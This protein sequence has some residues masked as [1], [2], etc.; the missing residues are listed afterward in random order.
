MN[1]GYMVRCLAVMATTAV[2]SCAAPVAAGEAAM[3]QR[4]ENHDPLITPNPHGKLRTWVPG[5]EIDTSNAF[6]QILGTNGRSCNTCHQLVAAWGT[7]VA[8]IGQRFEATYGTDP[9]FR[10]VDGANS[11]LMDVS[12]L[13]ARREAYSML[14]TYG[15][16]RIHMPMP[17][18]AEF[19][20][21]DVDDPWGYASAQELSL[22]RRPLPATNLRFLTSVMWDG[23]E[24][25]APF[26]PPMDPGEAHA[27]LVDSLTQQALNATLGHAQAM[28]PPTP[29]QLAAIVAFELSLT[30]AQFRDRRAGRLDDADALGGPRALAIQRFYVGIN[31]PFGFNPTGEPFDTNAS[32]ILFNGLVSRPG[33][34]PRHRARALIERGQQLF[35]NLPITIT[36]VAGLNDVLGVEA[37]QGHCTTCHNTPNVGNHSSGAPLDVGVADAS[38]RE[39]GFPLYTLMNNDTGEIRKVTDPGL[40]MLTGEWEDIGKFK[41]P[42]LRGLAARAPYFH[43]G[44]AATLGEVIDFYNERFDIGITPRQKAALVAFLS[45]L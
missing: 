17:E 6:F 21:L 39:A 44:S 19:S 31:D 23:R 30:T 33:N 4:Q 36:G 20:L 2:L 13:K 40:A 42:K 12:T 24:T 25:V 5:G 18:D 45:A 15:V 7:S 38:R 29:E 1:R 3:A 14:L 43:N 11:P 16:I 41:G 9:I 10:L 37:F 32:M 22:F 28:E 27:D 34:G 35:K 8:R 26:L